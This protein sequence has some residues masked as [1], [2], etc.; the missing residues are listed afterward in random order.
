MHGRWIVFGD[1]DRPQLAFA[2]LPEADFSCKAGARS[3][4]SWQVD[5]AL[6]SGTKSRLSLESLRH[7][8]FVVS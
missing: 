5:A 7:L 6:V 1:V 8:V 2:C 3:R 4:A